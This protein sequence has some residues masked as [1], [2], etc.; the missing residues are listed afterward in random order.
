MI[1]AEFQ[2]FNYSIS[3]LINR[4][5]CLSEYCIQKVCVIQQLTATNQEMSFLLVK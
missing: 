3:C 4:S 1:S 5:F 2:R